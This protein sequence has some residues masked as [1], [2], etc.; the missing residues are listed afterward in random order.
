MYSVQYQLCCYDDG[1]PVLSL[2]LPSMFILLPFLQY[3]NTI[4]GVK[5]TSVRDLSGQ[6]YDSNQPDKKPVCIFIPL[7]AAI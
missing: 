3:P 1:D 6:G 7:N 4:G 2:V 5:V